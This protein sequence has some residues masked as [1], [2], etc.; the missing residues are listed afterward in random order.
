M[1]IR[2]ER[3]AWPFGVTPELAE[4]TIDLGDV[5]AGLLLQLDRIVDDT[6]VEVLATKLGITI[7]S[8]ALEDTIRAWREGTCSVQI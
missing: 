8:Q 1:D 2:K 5:G 6:V 7:G 4:G 3:T